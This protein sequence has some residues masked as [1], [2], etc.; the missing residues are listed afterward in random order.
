M[1]LKS[2]VD[3]AKVFILLGGV[4][5]G[6]LIGA[7]QAFRFT[8][9]HPDRCYYD[10]MEGKSTLDIVQV[11]FA[12]NGKTYTSTSPEDIKYML[13]LFGSQKLWEDRQWEDIRSVSC[14]LV[15]RKGA[16]LEF[17]VSIL[18]V[19]QAEYPTE[20]EVSFFDAPHD[21]PDSSRKQLLQPMP[22]FVKEQFDRFL[23]PPKEKEERR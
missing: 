18:A 14:T 22:T 1:S 5:G 6:F 2:L 3:S 9:A 20:I 13:D 15:T 21:C 8:Q 11:E 7:G 4:G 12:K 17:H 23:M 10:I 19:G 16:K